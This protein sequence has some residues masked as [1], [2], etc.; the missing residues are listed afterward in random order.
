ML[1]SVWTPVECANVPGDEHAAPV[2]ISFVMDG[3]SDHKAIT[4]KELAKALGQA[5]ELPNSV[6]ARTTY[7]LAF[8]LGQ[9]A[10]LRSQ[11]GVATDFPF[12]FSGWPKATQ[13][14]FYSGFCDGMMRRPWL[15]TLE[16]WE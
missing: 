9:L 3:E 13:L 7:P 6:T 1:T 15:Y 14:A 5:E 11:D 8:W 16:G 4:A 12:G 10:E 2:H